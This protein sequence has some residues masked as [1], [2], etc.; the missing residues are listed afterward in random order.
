MRHR[1]FDR[2]LELQEENV[3]HLYSSVGFVD[4]S[5]WHRTYWLV[6]SGMR[7]GYGGWPVTGR[8][9]PAGRILAMGESSIY[10]FGRN[11]YVHFGSHVGIDGRTVFHFRPAQDGKMPLTHYRLFAMDRAAP[12]PASAQAKA[13]PG[14]KKR[15]AKP[16]APPKQYRWTQELPVLVRAMV[17]A[18]ETLFVAG[19]P[20]GGKLSDLPDALEGR[21]G[22]LLQAVSTSDGQ[23]LAEHRLDAPPV[24]DGLVAAGGKLY[25]TT[26]DGQV[27]CFGGK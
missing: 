23:K 6:G 12:N 8:Q 14:Q 16:A 3:P 5:W 17:L 22:G 19:P 2:S 7:S 10:G 18:E 26:M 27:V 13:K 25:L 21:S 15:R 24:F 20:N 9:V 1:R 11:Q 4:D